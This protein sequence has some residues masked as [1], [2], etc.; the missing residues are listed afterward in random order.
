VAVA[1]GRAPLSDPCRGWQPTPNPLA[2]GDTWLSTV[3]VE[4]AAARMQAADCTGPQRSHDR[5]HRCGQGA[6]R[7]SLRW[8]TGSP[9]ASGLEWVASSARIRQGA[10]P[11]A[12]ATGAQKLTRCKCFGHR[13]SL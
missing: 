12:T 5:S 13:R 3:D 8:L 2:T 7:P 6:A 10:R 1:S 9:V 4:S 11:E